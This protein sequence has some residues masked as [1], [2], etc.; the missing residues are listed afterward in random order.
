MGD[1]GEL[2]RKFPHQVQTRAAASDAK[3]AL[4]MR[5]HTAYKRS[6]LP[7]SH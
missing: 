2:S 5:L 3:A 7:T 1:V 6:K 4:A